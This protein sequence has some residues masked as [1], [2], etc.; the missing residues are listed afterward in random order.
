MWQRTFHAISIVKP[1]A[2]ASRDSTT[3]VH[4]PGTVRYPPVNQAL[5][6]PT[7]RARAKCPILAQFSSAGFLVV[8][9]RP[10]SEQYRSLVPPI[11][12]EKTPAF[13]GEPDW[14]GM[15][16]CLEQLTLIN[17]KFDDITDC[18]RCCGERRHERERDKTRPIITFVPYELLGE[19]IVEYRTLDLLIYAISKH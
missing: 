14:E 2:H 15:Q 7:E 17:K 16:H 5:F 13:I 3:S 6:P 18:V 9:E 12:I 11:V 19:R 1:L 10:T 4:L 8:K